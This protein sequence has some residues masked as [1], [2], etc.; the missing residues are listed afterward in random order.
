V[1]NQRALAHGERMKKTR[2]L[3][4]IGF[5][6]GIALSVCAPSAMANI[7]AINFA[8]SQIRGAPENGPMG[9]MLG[10]MIGPL[11]GDKAAESGQAGGRPKEDSTQE[12]LRGATV[13]AQGGPPE[14]PVL[15]PDKSDV[16][17]DA[18]INPMRPGFHR[19]FTSVCFSAI[20]TIL[21]GFFLWSVVA[22]VRTERENKA[23]D[24]KNK[25]ERGLRF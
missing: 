13:V 12:G 8:L 6:V 3:G 20:G 22:F 11:G 10:A 9:P 17:G 16:G 14:A 15:A 24:E 21:G 4:V 19:V 5:V 25:K 1:K 18:A 2:G 7:F 23:R